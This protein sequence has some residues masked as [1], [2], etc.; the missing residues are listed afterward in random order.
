MLLVLLFNQKKNTGLFQQTIK[1]KPNGITEVTKSPS[2]NRFYKGL[3]RSLHIPPLTWLEI[4]INRN[5]ASPSSPILSPR[6]FNLSP[7]SDN[8]PEK[9]KSRQPNTC[10]KWKISADTSCQLCPCSLLRPSSSY[11]SFRHPATTSA[12][13]AWSAS[14]QPLQILN[15]NHRYQPLICSEPF[16]FLIMKSKPFVSLDLTTF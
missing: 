16:Q 9:P 2:V 10:I 4:E 14:T 5:S 7:K 1:Q 8:F 11:W 12:P 13:S 15:L 6:L 3:N